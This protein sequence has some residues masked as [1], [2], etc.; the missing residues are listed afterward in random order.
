M[1]ARL[2]KTAG[3]FGQV[4]LEGPEQAPTAAAVLAELLEARGAGPHAVGR[5]EMQGGM[6]AEIPTTEWDDS[7]QPSEISASEFEA[8]WT[9]ARSHLERQK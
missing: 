8:I 1:K 6:T 5:Y 7:L 4:E 9:R 2:M 3:C